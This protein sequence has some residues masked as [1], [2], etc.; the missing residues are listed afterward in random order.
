V[1][2]RVSRP[3][4]RVP[5]APRGP[6]ER[7]REGTP[8]WIWLLLVLGI[9]LLA[10]IGFLGAQIFAGL[11]PGATP[12]PSASLVQVPNWVGDPISQVRVEAEDLGLKIDPR[13]E[14]SDTVAENDVIRTE[15]PAGEKIEKGKTVTVFVSS[16]TEQ[17]VVPS[18]RGQTRDE[19][20]S[21]LDAKGL[22]LGNVDQQYD[23]NVAA[24]A[25][26]SSSPSAGRPVAKGSSVDIVLSLGPT[27]SPTPSPT[28]VPTPTPTPVPTDT[29]PPTPTPE[30]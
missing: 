17:V 26:I 21:T 23:P 19:A 24:G 10:T 15:P 2:P 6:I 28:P 11:S 9:A 1:P 25:V 22:N 13:S 8:W 14:N 3:A 5:V 29:P 4:D 7:D 27:P 20:R 30:P 18:L 12:S 16:G